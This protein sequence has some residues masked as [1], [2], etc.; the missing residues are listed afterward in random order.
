MEKMSVSAIATL[1]VLVLPIIFS[2]LSK[3]SSYGNSALDSTD[4][5]LS[6]RMSMYATLFKT[7][8][9]ELVVLGVITFYYLE[10]IAKVKDGKTK[11]G[12]NLG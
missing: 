6:T 4:S 12:K 10:H 3:L 7:L 5:D 9:L 11:I 2:F 1:V 8:L